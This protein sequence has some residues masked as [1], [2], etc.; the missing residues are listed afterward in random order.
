MALIKKIT[1]ENGIS[2]NY[3]R[4]VSITNIVN[5]QTIIEIASYTSKSKRDEEKDALKK[6][7]KMDVFIK[8]KF[9]N[10]DYSEN[11]SVSDAYEYIKQLERFENSKDDI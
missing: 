11:L 9:E 2:V 7:A 8:T 4:I 5:N 3:H 10:F 1:L 6:G